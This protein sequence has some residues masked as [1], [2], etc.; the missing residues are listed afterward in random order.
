MPHLLSRHH[1]GG[2]TSKPVLLVT[3]SLNH[4][5][6]HISI[7]TVTH[8]PFPI[9]QT[10][11]ADKQLSLSKFFKTFQIQRRFESHRTKLDDLLLELIFSETQQ[12]FPEDAKVKLVT[13]LR[14]CFQF[15]GTSRDIHL[16]DDTKSLKAVKSC[17][18]S[19]FDPASK[20]PD[21]SDIVLRS[22]RFGRTSMDH[23]I[24]QSER[25]DEIDATTEASNASLD[26]AA[27]VHPDDRQHRLHSFKSS[28]DYFVDRLDR[29]LLN[30][31][32]NDSNT[33]L[34]EH[35]AFKLL[36]DIRNCV[37]AGEIGNRIRHLTFLDTV[38]EA[39]SC[40]EPLSALTSKLPANAASTALVGLKTIRETAE[41]YN[42]AKIEADK[43]RT[44]MFKRPLRP[45]AND[46]ATTPTLPVLN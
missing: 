14:H 21:D 28:V 46:S 11:L 25:I 22:L 32:F 41:L 27:P 42:A 31:I 38:K 36:S 23:Y 5:Q 24:S 6:L 18:E 35:P 10:L 16:K 29:I 20:L 2:R 4:I 33:K 3:L 9:V 39:S 17:Y 30:S 15:N 45:V 26:D 12:R 37:G 19:L 8:A 1:R 40:L 34:P 7:Q 13:D 44:E 43:E